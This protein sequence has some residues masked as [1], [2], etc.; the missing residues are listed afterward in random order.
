MIVVPQWISEFQTKT[1]VVEET[2][3]FSSQVD[4]RIFCEVRG[5]YFLHFL[6]PQCVVKVLQ[7]GSDFFPFLLMALN[8][9]QNFISI[10]ILNRLTIAVKYPTL[11]FV[12]PLDLTCLFPLFLPCS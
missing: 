3:T 8:E 10:H 12:L 5:F 9:N 4:E 11:R 6:R 7:V 2:Y 1:S